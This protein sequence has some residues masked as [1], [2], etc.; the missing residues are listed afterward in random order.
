MTEHDISQITYKEVPTDRIL[1]GAIEYLEK[2]E[3]SWVQHTWAFDD[4]NA[5]VSALHPNACRFCLSA[6]IQ[7]ATYD[8]HTAE[9]I[10]DPDL[11]VALLDDHHINADCEVQI[12]IDRVQCQIDIHTRGEYKSIVAWND[13]KGRTKAEVIEV[14]LATIDH[15]KQMLQRRIAQMRQIAANAKRLRIAQLRQVLA[16]ADAEENTN[17]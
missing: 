7:R 13:A 5:R 8:I 10:N 9:A 1:K 4:Q 15:P 16:P 2:E 11:Q 12:A 14:V 3:N 17:K 6:A